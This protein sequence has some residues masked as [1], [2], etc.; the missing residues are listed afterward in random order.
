[1]RLLDTIERVRESLNPRL[2]LEGVILT[3]MDAR[4]NLSRQ[5]AGEVR[6][7]LGA[8][9]LETEIPRT[10]RPSAA[11]SPGRPARLYDVRADGARARACPRAWH[12]KVSSSR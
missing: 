6:Q 1:A 5:V 3:M 12:R 4:N 8:R 11:P 2:T 10:V 7:H 9:G